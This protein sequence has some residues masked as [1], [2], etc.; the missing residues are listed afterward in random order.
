M[1]GIEPV[2]LLVGLVALHIITLLVAYWRETTASTA[3]LPTAESASVAPAPPALDGEPTADDHTETIRCS[4]CGT[5]NVAE[6]AYCRGCV[7]DLRGGG[8]RYGVPPGT[9]RSGSA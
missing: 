9:L 7:A 3:G 6:Y 5:R 8:R 4:E 2:W 1:L